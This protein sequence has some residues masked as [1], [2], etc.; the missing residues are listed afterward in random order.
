MKDV[1]AGKRAHGWE[2]KSTHAGIYAWTSGGNLRDGAWHPNTGYE[3]KGKEPGLTSIHPIIWQAL[4][5][6]GWWSSSCQQRFKDA[7]LTRAWPA[8]GTVCPCGV[9]VRYCVE[10][11]GLAKDTGWLFFPA[12]LRYI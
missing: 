5:Q 11:W 7:E 6:G 9:W 8:R 3:Q 1:G 4:S 10:G 2:G 12:L